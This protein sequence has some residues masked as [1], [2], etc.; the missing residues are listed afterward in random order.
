M[1]IQKRNKN[2]NIYDVLYN[3]VDKLVRYYSIIQK[4][5]DGPISHKIDEYDK[6]HT[7]DYFNIEGNS[8]GNSNINIGNTNNDNLVF[9][10]SSDDVKDI[11]NNNIESYHNNF[12]DN[13]VN[14]EFEASELYMLN[15]YINNNQNN[16]YIRMGLTPD[17]SEYAVRKLYE[18][19]ISDYFN[20]FDN[21]SEDPS[22][23]QETL[24]KH[25]GLIPMFN[26]LLIYSNKKYEN[27]KNRFDNDNE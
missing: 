13:G 24:L 17:E 5:N 10:E 1:N 20:Y 2:T 8:I 6:V 14:K 4:I 21:G 18:T 26:D 3:N 27:L 23:Y 7:I 12:I 11:I 25:D 9:Y 19:T 22:E 15:N 16:I